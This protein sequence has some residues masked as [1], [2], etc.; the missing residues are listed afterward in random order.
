MGYLKDRVIKKIQGWKTLFL[1]NA[2][3]ETLIKA[4]ITAIPTH[5]IT[6]LRLP[7]TWCEDILRLIARVWWN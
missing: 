4:V 3:K 7:K 1:N 2:G 6:L 5:V